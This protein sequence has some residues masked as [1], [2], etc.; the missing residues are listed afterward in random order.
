MNPET[1][2]E[3]WL[4]A[5][6]DGKMSQCADRSIFPNMILLYSGGPDEGYLIDTHPCVRAFVKKAGLGFGIP[7]LHNGQVH[8]YVPDFLIQFNDL[9]R[10]TL[11]LETKGYDLLAEVKQSAAKRWVEAVNAE[12]RLNSERG[13]GQW[14]YVMARSVPEIRHVLDSV[15]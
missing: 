11:V 9:P 2:C 6:M 14:R 1:E 8:E 13:H 4:M 3:C 5:A 12:S 7:Y 10:V 15:E